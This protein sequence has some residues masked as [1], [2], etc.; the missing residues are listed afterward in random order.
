MNE[1]FRDIINGIK[2]IIR[3]V[4]RTGERQV[5]VS[6]Y[7]MKRKVFR[8]ALEFLLFSISVVFI[9]AGLV[10]LLDRWFGIEWVLL[11]T[12]LIMLNFVFLTAKFK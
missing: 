8:F 11:I 5:T 4:V 1:T 6:F 7:R 9:L 3:S 12:G 2:D 10:L